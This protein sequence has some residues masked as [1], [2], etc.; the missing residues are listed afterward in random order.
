MAEIPAV[1]IVYNSFVEHVHSFLVCLCCQMTRKIGCITLK[2][3]RR[4]ASCVKCSFFW[5]VF[6]TKRR[7]VYYYRVYRNGTDKLDK[8]TRMESHLKILQ[9]GLGGR[10]PHYRKG[11]SPDLRLHETLK[12]TFGL[13]NLHEIYTF[14]TIPRI[15]VIFRSYLNLSCINSNT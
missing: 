6:W 7:D 4:V 5:C 12:I 8:R 3:T 1:Q 2:S 11:Y 15:S 10:W 9:F 14:E 13:C